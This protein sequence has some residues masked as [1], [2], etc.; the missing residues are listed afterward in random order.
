MMVYRDSPKGVV[1]LKPE[2][3]EGTAL[4]LNGNLI[5]SVLRELL[6]QVTDEA[7]LARGVLEEINKSVHSCFNFSNKLVIRSATFVLSQVICNMSC[8]FKQLEKVIAQV[9]VMIR[10]FTLNNHRVGY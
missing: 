5:Q 3:V 7:G 1:Q 10:K 6:E 4:F 8:T 2:D 9:T